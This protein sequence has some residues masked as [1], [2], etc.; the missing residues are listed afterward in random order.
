[1]PVPAVQPAGPDSPDGQRAPNRLARLATPRFSRNHEW[2]SIYPA[3]GHR[4]MVVA[5]QDGQRQRRNWFLLGGAFLAVCALLPLAY[6]ATA[7]TV[8]GHAFGLLGWVSA[9]VAAIGIGLAIKGLAPHPSAPRPTGRWPALSTLALVLAA[10]TGGASAAMDADRDGLTWLEEDST[11]SGDAD[12]DGDGLCDGGFAR[13]CH[14]PDGSRAF[15]PGERDYGTLPWDADS[16]MDG[17]LDGHEAGFWDPDADGR[18]ADLD[19]DL[20]PGPWDNDSDGDGLADGDEE[21]HSTDPRLDDTDGDGLTDGDEVTY[22]LTAPFDADSDGDGLTDGREVNE[23]HTRPLEADTDRDGLSDGNETLV[24]GTDPLLRDS[25]IDGTND[26][27]ELAGG[28]DPRSSDSDQDTDR[29]GLSNAYEYH[30]G[31]DPGSNDTDSDGMP[32]AYEYHWGFNITKADGSLDFDVDGLSNGAEFLAGSAPKVADT[33]SDGL[34]DGVEVNQARSDPLLRDTDRDLCADGPELQA[35]QAR[36][37]AAAATDFDGDG[38]GNLRDADADGD[39]IADCDE[40]TLNIRPDLADTDGDGRSDGAELLVSG[41]LFDPSKADTDGDGVSD[42]N[43]QEQPS[44]DSDRDGLSAAAEQALGTDPGRPDTDCDGL[45]DG[46]EATYWRLRGVSLS[47]PNPLLVADVDADGV[48]DGTELGAMASRARWREPQITFASDPLDVDSDDDG[49][50]DVQEWENNGPLGCPANPQATAPGFPLQTQAG[51]P[52][53]VVAASAQ[54]RAALAEGTTYADPTGISYGRA[55][56][57][58]YVQL[59]FGLRMPV[60][61]GQVDTFLR[62]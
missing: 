19:G 53:E 59:A 47:S 30:V 17:L 49:L 18:V 9:A 28:T 35:W 20:L 26:R 57:T 4:L 34:L 2:V 12:S 52:F 10:A 45:L 16:D 38:L 58:F 25:D 51:E 27:D 14:A 36:G 8:P 44:S 50:T 7:A 15:L 31:S 60:D 48:A 46:S 40:F 13:A 61:A 5:L 6:G 33:D 1:M 29:D 24:H 21:G 54:K 62:S 55:G 3:L 11:D 43:D 42:A 32:D 56:G 23:T 22:Y 37:P 41:G 39:G